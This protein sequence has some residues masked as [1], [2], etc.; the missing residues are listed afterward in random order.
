MTTRPG[1][2][3]APL[4]LAATLVTAGSAAWAQLPSPQDLRQQFPEA[5]R[6]GDGKIDREEFHLRSVEVFY[7]LDKDRKGYLVLVDL[8]GLT[9]EDFK[10]A[11]RKGDGKLTLDEF[12]N[13]RFRQFDL[14]DTDGDG[15]LTLQEVEVYVN[16]MR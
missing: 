9:P 5:D 16:R 2:W 12:L 10:A 7:V 3:L 8:R 6:N 1:R 11:D 13:A 15:V 14:A 4:T